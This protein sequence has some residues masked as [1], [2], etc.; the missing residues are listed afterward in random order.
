MTKGVM[1]QA[2][3]SLY[4][5]E[6]LTIH[7]KEESHEIRLYN[8]IRQYTDDHRDGARGGGSGLGWDILLGWHLHP[9]GGRDVRSVGSAGG[10]GAAY[11]AGAAWGRAC[12]PFSRGAP[13]E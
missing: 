1:K 10:G 13:V 9:R 3:Y 11:A 8:S 5:L 4:A 7:I 2:L 12:T 6:K